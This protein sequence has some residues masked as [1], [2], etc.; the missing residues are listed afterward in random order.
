VNF[1]PSTEPDAAPES[2]SLSRELGRVVDRKEV[3]LELMRAL[4][5]GYSAITSGDSIVPKWRNRLTTLG[6]EVT[7][8]SGMPGDSI[9]LQ[10]VAHDVDSIGRLIVRDENVISSSDEITNHHSSATAGIT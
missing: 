8:A 2:T 5:S 10:G 4:E 1:D 7:I 3:F 6:R 9:D